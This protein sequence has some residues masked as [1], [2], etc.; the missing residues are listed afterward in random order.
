MLRVFLFLFCCIHFLSA[1]ELKEK[2]QSAFVEGDY[3]KALILYDSLV[4]SS[5]GAVSDNARAMKAVIYEEYLGQLDSALSIYTYLLQHSPHSRRVRRWKRRSQKIEKLLPE[6]ELYAA[7]RM[8][9]MSREKAEDKV[10]KL[11]SLF[12]KNP[13][14]SKREELGRL[15]ITQHND[16]RN[17]GKALSVMETLK[18]SGITFKDEH[19]KAAQVHAKRENITTLSWIVLVLILGASLFMLT[20]VDTRQVFG[21]FFKLSLGWFIIIVIYLLA[22][23]LHFSK[24]ANNPFV[25][26]API[27]LMGLMV[28]PLFWLCLSSNYFKSAK[29]FYPVG[30]LPAL[31][32]IFLLYHSFLYYQKQPMVIMDTFE[33]R[34]GESFGFENEEIEDGKN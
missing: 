33:D 28:V 4:I 1:T 16:L 3:K 22:Y 21:Y 17:F 31:L 30:L 8:T 2:A 9:L 10:G 15:L 6:K 20:K 12:D 7:Y 13:E 11:Q 18:E 23:Y 25:W 19:Y 29:L 26:Y 27:L 5:E 14:F 32:L 34:L 24:D